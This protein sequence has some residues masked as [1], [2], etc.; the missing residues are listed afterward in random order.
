MATR[1][2]TVETL[3]F[4]KEETWIVKWETLTI[5]NADG[6][7][8]EMPGA[9][10]RSIQFI[11]TFGSGGTIALQGSNDGVN[12]ES[13]TDPQG[14]AISKTAKTIEM[15]TELTRYV[16]PFVSA[17]DGT[18]DLDAYLLVKRVS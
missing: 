1:P 10:D 4:Y 16:R 9:S 5:A 13:L 8:F 17:G 7:P 11:G 2:F 15:I 14:N 12:W 18:T 6:A 3:P